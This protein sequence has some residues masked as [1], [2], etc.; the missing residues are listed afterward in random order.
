MKGK[1]KSSQ[2]RVPGNSE[3]GHLHLAFAHPRLKD[4]QMGDSD[5][6][7]AQLEVIQEKPLVKRCYDLWYG[8]LLADAE[9]VPL[10]NRSRAIVEL[11]SGSSYVKTIRPDVITSDV[12]VGF[13]DL[14]LDA[15]KLPFAT[16]SLRAIFMCHTFHHIPDVELFFR[17]AC[18][19][20]APGGVISMVEVT[21]TP[22]ARWFFSSVHPEPYDDCS[23]QWNFPE[24]HSILDSNQALSWIVL[25]RDRARFAELFPQL[26]LERWTYLPWLSYLLSGGVNLR[27]FVPRFLAPAARLADSVLKPLDHAFAIHWHITLRKAL[28]DPEQRCI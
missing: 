14:V 17:E 13:A 3:N 28:R 5:W 27:S 6:F 7:R 24:R 16:N 18:R 20:L 2:V 21:H 8:R 22:F 25:F 9:S 1:G 11:G 19:T 26:Q 12:V 23:G 10:S 4:L 15:R